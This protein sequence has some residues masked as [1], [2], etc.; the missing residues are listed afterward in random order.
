MKQYEINSYLLD[1]IK[2]FLE[3]E[4]K[5]VSLQ[6]GPT[7]KATKPT[8]ILDVVSLVRSG[9]RV[10]GPRIIKKAE[11]EG[12]TIDVFVRPPIEMALTISIEPQNMS[13]LD[14]I[15]ATAQ[16]EL[17]MEKNKEIPVDKWDW[18]GNEGQ[19][20][21]VDSSHQEGQGLMR[22]YQVQYAI[23]QDYTEE[24]KRVQER[25]FEALKK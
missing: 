5:G 9:Q 13:L 12:R 16:V 10:N 14:A 4:I 11:F 17:V 6:L 2:S 21:I 24:I 23:E 3:K 20:L 7:A 22:Q 25:K 15:N 18:T 8:L 19:P 1:Y